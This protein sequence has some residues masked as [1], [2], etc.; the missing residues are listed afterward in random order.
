M[1]TTALNIVRFRVKPGFEEEF[2]EAHRTL[3]QPF[4]GFL[5]GE[6]VRTGERTYCLVGQW[7]SY[8]SLADAR[9]QMVAL[10]DTFRHMLEDLGG[11]LGVTDPVSGNSVFRLAP[12]PAAKKRAKKSVS[13]KR[14]AKKK[15]AAKKSAAKKRP[16]RTR[17]KRR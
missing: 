7:R 4:K 14:P 12:S 9:P 1:A 16:P 11:N 5:G 6:L 17:V 13:K 2:V 3:S 15:S 10:L 8:D